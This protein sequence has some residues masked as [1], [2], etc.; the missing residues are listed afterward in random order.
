MLFPR[1]KLPSDFISRT[2]KVGQKL[3]KAL[4]KSVKPL[5]IPRGFVFVVIIQPSRGP[6]FA[7]R[8]YP[9][10]KKRTGDFCIVCDS[11]Q[12]GSLFPLAPKNH[13]LNNFVWVFLLILSGVFRL[14][15]KY[16]LLRFLLSVCCHADKDIISDIPYNCNAFIIQ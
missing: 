10:G 13:H 4:S 5:G 16:G 14:S 8:I 9:S 7:L 15:I 1:L 3:V 12:S 11:Q 2:L 6:K